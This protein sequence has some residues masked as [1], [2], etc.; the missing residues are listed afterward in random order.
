MSEQENVEVVESDHLENEIQDNEPKGHEASKDE[1]QAREKGWVSKEE[2]EEQGKDPNL[3]VPA[4]YFNE[5]G[6]MISTIKELQNQVRNFDS[7]LAKNN[8]FHKANLELKL[9]EL[10]KQKVESVQL[11]DAESVEQLDQEIDQVKSQINSIDT[12]PQLNKSDIS[13]EEEWMNNNA[14]FS[15]SSARAVY[16]QS[17]AQ[18]L[19]AKGVRGEQ[20]TSE[21]ESAVDKEFQPV[22]NNRSKAPISSKGNKS[23]SPSK[24]GAVSWGSLKGEELAIANSLKN[25][26]MKEKDILQMVQDSRA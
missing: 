13:H 20:L 9:S 19:I 14:W 21:V 3:H 5:K 11:A 2:W 10:K 6:Q 18:K 4:K 12:E 25:N 17:V 16:A 15:T 8:E 23:S 26:G 24:K 1:M 22:N 7:R